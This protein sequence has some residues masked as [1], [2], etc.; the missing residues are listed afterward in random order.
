VYEE[1]FEQYGGGRSGGVWIGELSKAIKE[2]KFAKK[3][4]R[5][6]RKGG[7]VIKVRKA[8]WGIGKTYAKGVA[9][10]WAS[11]FPVRSGSAMGC[12]SLPI[13]RFP[14]SAS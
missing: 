1:H 6:H 8:K 4:V 14:L 2:F 3:L 10:G 11:L 12:I 7:S 5:N 13:Y 9:D